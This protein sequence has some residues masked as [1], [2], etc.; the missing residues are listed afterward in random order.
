MRPGGDGEAMLRAMANGL[1]DEAVRHR[2]GWS[3]RKLRRVL[4]ETMTALGARSRF[5]AGYLFGR[6]EMTP[7][8]E[9]GV[10]AP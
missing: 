6:D 4:T 1:T 10:G 9:E 2:L 5:E 7:H 3:R 8:A